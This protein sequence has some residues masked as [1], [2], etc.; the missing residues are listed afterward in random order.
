MISQLFVLYKAPLLPPPPDHAHPTEGH[1]HHHH[2]LDHA[3]LY[4]DP[5]EV[6]MRA[7]LK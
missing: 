7:A 3:H 6:F 2:H 5:R 4:N 1:H